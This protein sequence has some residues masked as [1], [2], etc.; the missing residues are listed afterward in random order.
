MKIINHRLF[1]DD[2]TPFPFIAT[3]N[4]GGELKASYLVMHYTAGPSADHSIKWLI[5]PTA[6]ASAH[7]VIGRDGSVTQLVPFNR[8]AWHAGQSSWQGLVGMNQYSIGIEMDNAGTLNK[9]GDQYQAW[10]GTSYPADQVIEATHKSEKV[11]RAWHLYT[12]EQ[13][14]AALEVGSLIVQTYGLKDV[15]G[16]EDIAPRRKFDPGPAFPMASFHSRIF[17]RA[18]DQAA[19]T[20]AYRTKVNL[21]I[22]T[23][24]GSQ[25]APLPNS[26]LPAGTRLQAIDDSNSDWLKVH[27]LDTIQGAMDMQGWV[28]KQFV[29]RS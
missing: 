11:K 17:G 22:R 18:D 24:P 3:P 19:P 9:V 25:Y 8:V 4:M 7:L 23:G 2:G 28:S 1:Q 15:I 20:V 26:P 16:H 29:V 5:N 12:P 6:K 10:F 13:L 21:H 27:V 14:F